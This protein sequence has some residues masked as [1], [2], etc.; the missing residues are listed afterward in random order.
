MIKKLYNYILS[1]SDI[2]L[3]VSLLTIILFIYGCANNEEENAVDWDGFNYAKKCSDNS[4]QDSGCK[5]K[6]SAGVSAIGLRGSR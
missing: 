3:L 6:N 1:V 4:V 2:C 5:K